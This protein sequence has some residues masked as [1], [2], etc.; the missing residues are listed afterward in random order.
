ME[1]QA[2]R[3]VIAVARRPAYP[4]GY[5][6]APPSLRGQVDPEDRQLALAS[7]VC[8]LLVFV[9]LI[10]A[11]MSLTFGIGVLRR[12]KRL[13]PRDLMLAVVGTTLGT[14]NLAVSLV[15]LLPAF[16]P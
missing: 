2:G 7:V 8:G 16:L 4:L 3:E 1:D 10:P 15:L 11:A 14:V 9:P 13:R 12:A 5:A 6:S